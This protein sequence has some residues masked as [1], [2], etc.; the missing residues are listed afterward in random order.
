MYIHIHTY[1]I[2]FDFWETQICQNTNSTFPIT[3]PISTPVTFVCISNHIHCTL[4][5]SK[6]HSSAYVPKN[7]LGQID[8]NP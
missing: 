7:G 2:K 1:I 3:V 4:Q 6:G 5:Q 8:V